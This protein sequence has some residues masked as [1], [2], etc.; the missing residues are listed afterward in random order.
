MNIPVTSK[1]H[2]ETYICEAYVPVTSKEHREAYICDAYDEIRAGGRE[3]VSSIERIFQL[4]VGR[5]RTDEDLDQLID[6]VSR[7][8]ANATLAAELFRYAKDRLIRA[9][10][11][12]AKR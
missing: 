7:L 9:A 2:R 12:E 10:A 6:E 3:M 8:E 5:A 1:E 4:G 11:E